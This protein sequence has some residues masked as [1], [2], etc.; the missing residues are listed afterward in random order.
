MKEQFVITGVYNLREAIQ[1][2]KKRDNISLKEAFIKAKFGPFPFFTGWNDQEMILPVVYDSNV[3][4][5]L[6]TLKKFQ[7]NGK[8]EEKR[9][10]GIISHWE[11]QYTNDEKEAV[12]HLRISFKHCE[13]AFLWYRNQSAE[14]QCKIDILINHHSIGP[15][16]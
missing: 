8:S 14:V 2:F 4:S 1:Y 12:K 13:E 15:V 11:Y 5:E 16:G 7:E 6:Q 10:D 9:L 3:L